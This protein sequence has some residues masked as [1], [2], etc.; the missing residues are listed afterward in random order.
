LVLTFSKLYNGKYVNL[1]I[2]I[3]LLRVFY[4]ETN[5]EKILVTEGTV[6]EL[7]EFTCM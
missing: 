3:Q 5:R 1:C 2:P 6:G 4:F 7:A